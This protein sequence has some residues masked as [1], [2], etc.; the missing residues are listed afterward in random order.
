MKSNF[1][2][3]FEGVISWNSNGSHPIATTKI[4]ASTLMLILNIQENN[5]INSSETLM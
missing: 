5:L 3:Y 4:F 2:I 1:I